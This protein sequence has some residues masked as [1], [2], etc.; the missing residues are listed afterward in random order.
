MIP[1]PLEFEDFKIEYKREK[2]FSNQKYDLNEVIK[3]YRSN[4]IPAGKISELLNINLLKS[5]P[6]I[7]E[8]LKKYIAYDT[9]NESIVVILDDKVAAIRRTKDNIKWKSFGSKSYIKISINKNDDVIF[10]VFGMLEIILCEI[11]NLSYIG[12]QS[13]GI[14]KNIINNEQFNEDLKR[15]WK[16]KV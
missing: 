11:F 10:V 4:K 6:K 12:F 16:V 2:K 15:K 14:A 1:N 9:F 13:D 7:Q 3:T 8:I 5:N